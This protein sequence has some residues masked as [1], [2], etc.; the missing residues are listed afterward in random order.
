MFNYLGTYG[1]VNFYGKKDKRWTF[2]RFLDFLF[3]LINVGMKM[4][5]HQ[6]VSHLPKHPGD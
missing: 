3:Q 1:M 2:I 5:V 4:N 6:A